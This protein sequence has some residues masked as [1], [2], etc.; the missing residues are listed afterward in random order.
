MKIINLK[1]ENVKKIKAVDITPV[2]NSV[3]ISGKNGQGKS[4]VLDSIVFALG[5]K[6]ALK[7]TPKPIRNGEKKASVTID[8]GKYKI[9]RTWNESGTTYLEVYSAD[10]AKYPSPQALLD[11]IVG[12]IS[13]DPLAFANMKPE[14]QKSLF[15]D[16]L[17]LTEQMGDLTQ[18]YR[19]QFD[20]RRMVGRD[21]K[22]AEGH[23]ASLV[24]PI[25]APESLVD[26]AV[27][28]KQ[29]SDARQHNNIISTWEQEEKNR[30]SEIEHLE[31]QLK[32]KKSELSVFKKTKPKLTRI[33]VEAIEDTLA[34][35]GEQNR[36]FS[37]TQAYQKAETSVVML[38]TKY[39]EYTKRLEEVVVQKNKMISEAK[40][41][42]PGLDVGSEGVY[43]NQIPFTQLSSAEQ[44]RVSLSI[45]MATNP[46]LRVMRIV[47]GSLLDDDNLKLI[48]EMAGKEDYQ[49]WIERVDD[50]GKVG[51]VIEDGEV[52]K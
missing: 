26:T 51:F 22:I 19:S 44:L 52:K 37:E 20:E 1:A 23:L 25:K 5:G 32:V 40:L 3:I 49:V 11:D 46:K 13:F 6:E 42:I 24:K 28:S 14:D 39:D 45:A 36:L 7:N 18:N 12:K 41:P 33:D 29:L 2:G 30:I 15:L 31:T 17:G 10:G 35:A 27:V 43:Y 9:V 38:R 16:V 8:L 47:D 4:S 48:T 50:S 34:N 21:L